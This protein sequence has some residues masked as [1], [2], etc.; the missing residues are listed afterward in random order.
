MSVAIKT[1]LFLINVGTGLSA[2]IPDYPWR[3]GADNAYSIQ[4]LLVTGMHDEVLGTIDLVVK[5]SREANGGTGR[6]MCEASINGIVFNPDNL[7]ETPH[8]IHTL[9]KAYE[10]RTG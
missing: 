1:T 10:W 4:G 8:F 7:N 6:I 5:L 2:G 3:L 9:W